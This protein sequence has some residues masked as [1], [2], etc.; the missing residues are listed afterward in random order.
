MKNSAIH[1]GFPYIIHIYGVV[2]TQ[3]KNISQNGFIFPNVR[4]ENRKYLKPPTSEWL[5]FYGKLVG[6]YTRQPWII[7]VHRVYTSWW[8]K[9]T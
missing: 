2:S 8:V 7:W 6:K 4:G 5:I 3:L 9:Q 1:V